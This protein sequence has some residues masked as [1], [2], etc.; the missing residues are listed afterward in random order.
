MITIPA[1]T[2]IAVTPYGPNEN[3][4]LLH[5]SPEGRYYYNLTLLKV[6]Y[7]L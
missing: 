6:Y 5:W 1:S 2:S 4:I 3:G 7:K